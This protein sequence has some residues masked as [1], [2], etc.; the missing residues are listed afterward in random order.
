MLLM[1]GFAKS[2]H[3]GLILLLSK[4]SLVI[5]TNEHNTSQVHSSC[6]TGSNR[7]KGPISIVL[8]CKTGALSGVP[9]INKLLLASRGL[10][11]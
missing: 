6:D 5:L 8:L 10:A 3:V 1:S 11:L 7:S 9:L 2:P 4:F